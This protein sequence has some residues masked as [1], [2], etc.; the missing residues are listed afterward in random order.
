MDLLGRKIEKYLVLE[1]LGRGG[2]GIVFKARDEELDRFVVLK[3]MK[4]DLAQQLLKRFWIE[5]RA[6]ASLSH[7]NIVQIYDFLKSEYGYFIVMEYVE[8][9]TLES[10]LQRKGILNN[11]TALTLFL[12][13]LNGISYAHRNKII[14]RDIKP[15]NILITKDHVVKVVDFGL[16]K[17]MELDHDSTLTKSGAG[18]IYYMSPERLQLGQVDHRSDIFSL[19][20]TFYE[21]LAGRRPFN[22]EDTEFTIAQKIVKGQIPPLDRLAPQ[23]PRP[24]VRIVMKALERNPDRRYQSVTAMIEDLAA[25]RN[26]KPAETPEPPQPTRRKYLVWGIGS[27]CL[28]FLFSILFSFLSKTDHSPLVS[29]DSTPDSAL[30]VCAP[31]SLGYTPLHNVKLKSGLQLLSFRKQN[32]QPLDTLLIIPDEKQVHLSF[33]L[34]EMTFKILK[35]ESNALVES[36]QTNSG[37]NITSDPSAATVWLDDQNMGVTPV[38]RND[39]SAGQHH[40]RLVLDHHEITERTIQF[41]P[42]MTYK[43]HFILSAQTGGLEL[44]SD[45]QGAA[46]F[47]DSREYG[48]TPL[49]RSSGLPLGDCIIALRKEGYQE[50][51]IPVNIKAQINRVAKIIL[52]PIMGLLAI[53]VEPWGSLYIDGQLKMEE[54]SSETQFTL[55]WGRHELEIKHTSLGVW[56]KS[57]FIKGEKER[58]YINLKKQ[59]IVTIESTPDKSVVSI[60]N[61]EKGETPLK[62]NLRTGVHEIKV[63][64]A[65]FVDRDNVRFVQIN[66]DTVIKFILRPLP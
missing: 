54:L 46:V 33:T 45:P 60:D 56:R 34:K 4:Q 29:I 30:V 6:Q 12:Q 35:S 15:K 47:I 50:G 11:E 10:L 51:Q 39:V 1:E 2:M 48:T 18:T 43:K 3:M 36:T 58:L 16:A 9:E 57:I 65:G 26:E 31:E 7:P 20:I 21:M 42:G 64:K 62:I 52:Q 37:I 5:V 25:F 22:D 19:G 41:K 63:Q 17:R 49:Q 61:K 28:L 23:T 44:D 32:W 24:L 14:H 59:Y 13:L 55:P 40:I 27:L 38:V 66:A 8:G 53:R